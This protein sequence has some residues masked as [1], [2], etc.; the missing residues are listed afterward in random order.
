MLVASTD[1]R[2]EPPLPTKNSSQ[3]LVDELQDLVHKQLLDLVSEQ[4]LAIL[5]FPDI[6]NCGDS[7]IWLGELAY[8]AKRHGKRPA[9]VSRMHDFS[10]RALAR[11][12]PDGPIF[13]HG[14]GNFGD[15]WGA[16]QDFREHVLERFPDRQVVQ[17]PQSIHYKSAERIEASKRAIGRH[18]DFVLLVRDTNSLEFAETHFDC[19]VR[20]CPDMAFCI[21]PIQAARPEFPVL[22][23]LRADLEKAGDSD[24]LDL[25]DTPVEDWITESKG[26][27]RLAKALGGAS[28]LLARR[29]RETRLRSLDAAAH[30]RFQRGI[31]QISRAQVIVT[32]RL[33]VHICSLLLGKPHA[34]LDNSYGKIRRFMDTF[35]GSTTLA[36]RAESLDDGIAWAREQAAAAL[37]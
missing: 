31:R 15:V 29:P 19:A 8:L 12:V 22:A 37:R 14:G 7:A 27:V 10:A 33:H 25:G 21:G 24:L 30:N 20:L 17:F 11:A 6:R 32:D 2:M 5:D 9:Y 34:V 35:S 28:A 1:R 16:H 26:R 18:K 3:S 4:P 23:M 36:Y 13:I